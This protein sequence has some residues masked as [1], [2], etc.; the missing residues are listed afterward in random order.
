VRAGEG[1][2]RSL[3]ALPCARPN[4]LRLPERLRLLHVRRSDCRTTF[5]SFTP[6]RPSLVHVSQAQE[7]REGCCL[8]KAASLPPCPVCWRH[9]CA[10]I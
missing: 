10:Q 5:P 8:S 4:A 3:P 7:G 1:L 6:G 2:L 9:V